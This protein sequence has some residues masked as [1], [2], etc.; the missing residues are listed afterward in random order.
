MS[1]I[2]LKII[3]HDIF[4]M[5]YPLK[6]TTFLKSHDFEISLKS[7]SKFKY[8]TINLKQYLNKHQILKN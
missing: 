5:K 7:I 1:F 6:I 4:G 2:Y 8:E 3:L